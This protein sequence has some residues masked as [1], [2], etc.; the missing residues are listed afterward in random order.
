MAVHTG[1]EF[2]LPVAD[3]IRPLTVDL[4][5]CSGTS[6]LSNPCWPVMGLLGQEHPSMGGKPRI[7]E[8][9]Y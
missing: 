2:E 1:N 8:D 7:V 6:T 9:I 5:R 4:A 3:Q